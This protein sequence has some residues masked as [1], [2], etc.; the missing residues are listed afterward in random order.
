MRP[1]SPGGVDDQRQPG[2]EGSSA[3]VDLQLAPQRV[4]LTP[5]GVDDLL[6]AD[7]DVHAASFGRVRALLRAPCSIVSRA[8]G[9][10]VVCAVDAATPTSS[11]GRAHKGAEDC[12]GHWSRHQHAERCDLP[13]SRSAVAATRTAFPAAPSQC[14]VAPTR[15]CRA[16]A[17]CAGDHT[18]PTPYLDRDQFAAAAAASTAAATFWAEQ[19][20]ITCF[21]GRLPLVSLYPICNHS[22]ARPRL[23]PQCHG[24]RLV[25]LPRRCVQLHFEPLILAALAAL[26]TPI[27]LTTD[28]AFADDWNMAGRPVWALRRPTRKCT[29]LFARQQAF[30]IHH[31]HF[32]FWL[33]RSGAPSIERGGGRA[34]RR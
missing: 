30:A 24:L 27:S 6:D 21:V 10:T 15:S 16:S 29:S 19:V 11:H 20:V 5:S 2:A 31:S 33:A 7:H 22:A 9:P 26:N 13:P 17:A 14:R 12:P 32:C 3:L 23:P 25:V 4:V 8:T 1:R 28:G 34:E 18:S